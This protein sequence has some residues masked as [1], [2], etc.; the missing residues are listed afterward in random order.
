MGI[1]IA[2]VGLFVGYGAAWLASREVRYL[3]RAGYE[4]FQI[5]R[6]RRPLER[7][8]ADPATDETTRTLLR[9][10]LESRAFA[11][12][13][14]LAAGRTY[15]AYT[16]VGRDTLLLVLT[17]AP[18]DCVCPHTWRYPI[19]GRVPYKG[20][21]DTR[22]AGQE[23]QRFAA[24]GYDTWLRPAGAF[25][26]L[27][28]FNDPLL[29]TALT[30]DRVELAATVFH[31]I[32]HNTVY[33]KGATPF[34]ESFAQ[35]V[36][37][38]AAEAFFLARGDTAAARRAADRWADEQVLGTFYDDFV[39]RL[40]R[41][42][43]TRPDPLALDSGRAALSAWARDQFAGPVGASLR[44]VRAGALADRPVNNAR[45]IGVRL[46]RTRLEWFEAWHARHGGDL[47]AAVA[48]LGSL[49]RGAEGD[50]A[51]ARL[52]QALN[53]PEEDPSPP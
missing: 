15:T 13:L 4:E 53:L 27:G 21:F 25:S 40:E 1:L 49:V 5:L 45:L 6:N 46:Y 11:D 39:G 18:P 32:A 14:G 19:V 17:A 30:G 47:A 42:Y 10:V 34:N 26:T 48:A 12:T 16:D 9:L 3:T 33:V 43:A 51:F 44:T 37:Y 2:A 31:E 52:E 7:L 8:I 41:F 23:E 38:R 20:F 24:R 35:W 22:M 36:G 50:E 29:S 28:W